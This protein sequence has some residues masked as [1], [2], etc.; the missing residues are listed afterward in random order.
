M[1]TDD[2]GSSDAE[3]PPP[4]YSADLL[5]DLHAGVLPESVSERLW[6]LVRND[7][8]AMEVISALDK[9]TEQ[10][11]ALGRDHSV[12]SPIPVD[13]AD[14]ITHALEKE[15]EFSD[16]RVVP[17]ARRRKWAAVAGGALAAAAAVVV[18]IAVVTPTSRPADPPIALP[19]TSETAS[20]AVLDLD[21][22]L[23]AGRLLTLIGSRELG[24]LENPDV[25]SEC[26]R[27]NGIDPSR[28]LLGSGEVRLDGAPGV[29][30]LLA[31]PQPPQITALVVGNSCSS[32]NPETMAVTDIG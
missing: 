23:D 16:S 15:R 17:L 27:A 25:L 8:H 7:P 9:V 26:L 5:S 4:P 12:A 10:L 1:A 31:G 21:S 22:D 20:P 30:L 3:L 2:V 14:R 32:G 18:A 19:S 28:T 6:P 24:S 29:L 11:G 13:V